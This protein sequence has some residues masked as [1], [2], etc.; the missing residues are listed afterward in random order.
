MF[1]GTSIPTTILVFKKC[2]E[3]QDN[4]L[5][6]DASQQFE[7]VKKDN[8]LRPDHIEKIIETYAARKTVDKLAYLSSLSEIAEND[9]NLNIPRYVDT[10]EPEPEVDLAAVT[11]DLAAARAREQKADALIVRFCKELGIEA[12]L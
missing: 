6:V 1:F 11:L 8:I 12:P 10:F 4:I 7:K 2:R 9:Y 5:F 3:D